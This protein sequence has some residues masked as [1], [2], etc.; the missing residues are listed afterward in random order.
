MMTLTPGQGAGTVGKDTAPVPDGQGG[1]LGRGDDPGGPAQVQRLAGGTAQDRRQPVQEPLQP[2]VLVA[3]AGQWWA[4]EA[5]AVAVQVL[6]AGVTAGRPRCI[7]AGPQVGVVL[8]A[9]NYGWS[10]P[11]VTMAAHV[12]YGAIL[13]AFLQVR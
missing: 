8:V 9:L 6:A 11:L 3:V 10:T 1:P 4:I 13:G 5:G 12:V 7:G 2:R